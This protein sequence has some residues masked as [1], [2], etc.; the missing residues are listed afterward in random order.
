[1][2]IGGAALQLLG[3]FTWKMSIVSGRTR[4]L[5][6]LIMI[7]LSREKSI[8]EMGSCAKFE[9]KCLGRD[10]RLVA[11]AE[12]VLPLQLPSRGGEGWRV[13]RDGMSIVCL[14]RLAPVSNMA[15]KRSMESEVRQRRKSFPPGTPKLE[16]E[17]TVFNVAFRDTVLASI[18]SR[19]SD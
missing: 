8:G 11:A 7:D 16:A 15:M 5:Q 10:C 18:Y 19:L 12:R 13:T 14:M 6:W 1:M 3:K 2:E 9:E 17:P 4:R